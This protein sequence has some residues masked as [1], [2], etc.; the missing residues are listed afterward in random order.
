MLRQPA[1]FRLNNRVIEPPVPLSHENI[2]G[3]L[4]LVPLKNGR[5]ERRGFVAGRV[6]EEKSDTQISH[7]SHIKEAARCCRV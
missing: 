6:R 4:T 7:T 5:S 1:Y 2:H 3:Y